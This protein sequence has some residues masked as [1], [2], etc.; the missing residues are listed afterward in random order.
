MLKTLREQY[1]EKER[2][3]SAECEACDI[4]MKEES[5]NQDRGRAANE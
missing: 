3:Q 2:K 5:V 4:M 1:I